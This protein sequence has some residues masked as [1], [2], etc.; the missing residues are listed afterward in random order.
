MAATADQVPGKTRRSSKLVRFL[1]RGPVHIVLVLLALFWITPTVGL[2][3]TSFRPPEVMSDSGW[4]TVFT[5]PAQLTVES[6]QSILSDDSLV[7]SLLNTFYITIPTT[8]GVVLIA[9]LA[10]YA[11]AWIDFRGRDWVFLIV[12]AMI[13][14]PLQ[15]GLVPMARLFGDIGIFGTV[16]AAI[17]FH[18]AFGLPFA[19]FLLRNFFIGL[20]GELLEAARIDGASEWQIFL[21]IVLPLGMPA[22]AALG[23]FQFLW[24]WN[25]LL[26]GLVFT[27]GDSIPITV[28]IRD[29][30]RQF[31]G[32][33]DIIAPGA[34]ISMVVPLIVFF[35]FQRYF[36][37]GLLAGSVK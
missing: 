34:F 36:V 1:S 17:L 20:P 24:T 23:I 4:W 7:Q 26:V 9:A 5:K 35:A 14:V 3:V 27:G 11:F 37:Q 19:I 25:D 6:Y 13:V 16:W 31:G 18:I 32:N 12:I 29:Q 22:I 15:M 2:L 30:L 8:I 10:A 21:R 28:F 33:L